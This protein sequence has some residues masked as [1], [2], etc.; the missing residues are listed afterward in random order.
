VAFEKDPAEFRE[1]AIRLLSVLQE[2]E[3]S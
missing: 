3:A 2:V 1:L